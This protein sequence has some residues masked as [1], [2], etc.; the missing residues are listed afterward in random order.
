MSAETKH[1]FAGW[2]ARRRVT[3]RKGRD[4]ACSTRSLCQQFRNWAWQRGF[5]V[6]LVIEGDEVVALA[7]PKSGRYYNGDLM[8][9]EE[10]SGDA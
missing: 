9:V 5:H 2:F 7:A 3:L 1:D 6:K 8:V 4:F 10:G